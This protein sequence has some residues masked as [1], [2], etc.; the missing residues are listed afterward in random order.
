MST[1]IQTAKETLNDIINNIIEECKNEGNLK[2]RIG[3]IGYRDIKEAERFR[4]LPFTNDTESVKKF[5]QESKAIGGGD[6]PED[7]Q[8]GLKLCL[9]QDW[10][11]ESVKRAVLISD[12]PSHGAN[13]F[14]MPSKDHYPD[15]TPDMPPLKNIIEQFKAKNIA[16]QIV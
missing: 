9:Q 6:Y 3:F 8:G 2:V 5:I 15:G 4:V 13:Y 11:E 1:W 14:H 10:T 16:L 12:A 7:V